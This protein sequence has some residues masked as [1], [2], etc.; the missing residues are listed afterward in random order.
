MLESTLT[1]EL[2]GTPTLAFEGKMAFA[3]FSLKRETKG[4]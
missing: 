3:I 4:R 2:S 1:A